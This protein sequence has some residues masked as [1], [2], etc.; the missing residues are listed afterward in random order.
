MKRFSKLI[1]LATSLLA[2]SCVKVN[3]KV[4]SN[5]IPYLEGLT[6]YQTRIDLTSDILEQTTLDSLSAMS[7]KKMVIGSIHSDAYGITRRSSAV[8]L[9]PIVPVLEV[10]LKP[11]NAR[12]RLQMAKDT[13]VTYG[14]ADASIIQSFRVYELPYALD[15]IFVTTNDLSDKTFEGFPQIVDTDPVYYGGDSLSF[16]FSEEFVGKVLATFQADS[17]IQKTPALYLGTLP[18]IY[19][20][21]NEPLAT[22]GRINMFDF[23]M[24]FDDSGYI[25]GNYIELAFTSDYKRADGTIRENVDT[26]FVFCLG[27]LHSPKSKSDIAGYAY[28]FSSS[29]THPEFT[30]DVLYVEGAAGIKPVIRAKKLRD[31]FLAAVADSLAAV[32]KDVDL[33][34]II[35]NKASIVLPYV[36]EPSQWQQYKDYPKYLSP[37]VRVSANVDSVQFVAYGGITDTSISTED[38]GLINRSLLRYSPDITHHFQSVIK[39]TVTGDEDE[40]YAQ[41]DVY[42]LV[43]AP[44]KVRN[45]NV[46][47]DSSYNDMYQAM[48]YS[49]YY[50]NMYGYG[51]GGYGYGYGGY[52]NYYNYGMMGMYGMYGNQSSNEVQYENTL[53]YSRYYDCRLC[54]PSSTI[55]K[56]HM[57]VTF[58]VIER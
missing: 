17:A 57:Q 3:D 5:Y 25:S 48:M 40:F 21:A 35:I 10:G 54:G 19:I 14:S 39:S 47:Y 30:G 13:L 28:N 12:M 9:Y 45:A 52:G 22:G 51:M 38:P 41:R 15:S 4:G 33:S 55:E 2:F 53:D 7:A 58:C 56:P 11:R 36:Y 6:V 24:S 26:S 1:L 29:E 31:A 44:E 27:N 20:T 42:L 46:D 49:Q 50:N 16:N 43:L 32:G 23:N 18:G 34:K 8:T 37:T